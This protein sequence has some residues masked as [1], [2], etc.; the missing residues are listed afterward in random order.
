MEIY[1]YNVGWEIVYNAEEIYHNFY[2][3][4]EKDLDVVGIAHVVLEISHIVLEISH[5]VLEISHIVLEILNGDVEIYNLA[6]EIY[7]CS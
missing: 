3:D 5:I 1:I 7:F 6:L 2:V 4:V